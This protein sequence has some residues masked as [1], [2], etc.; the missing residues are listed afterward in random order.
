MAVPAILGARLTFTFAD[1]TA[2]MLVIATSPTAAFPSGANGFGPMDGMSIK[3]NRQVQKSSIFRGASQLVIPRYNPI[4]SWVFSVER[5]FSTPEAAASFVIS[6]PDAVPFQGELIV[7]QF[8]ATGSILRY[9]PLAVVE[10]VEITK[11]QEVGCV[12]RYALAF[13]GP[14]QTSP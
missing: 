12:A 2:G 6:H 3:Q 1:M 8:S 7:Q 14:W 9:Q 11:H 5:S 4:N 13:N 10:S